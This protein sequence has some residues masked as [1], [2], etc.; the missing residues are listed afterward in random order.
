VRTLS[1]VAALVTAALACLEA[2]SLKY[3]DPGIPR[4][5]DGQPNLSAPA[6]RLNGKPDLS[7]VWQAERT[8]VS[9]FVRVLGP[10]LPA[11]QPDLNDI[12][13][14][15]LNV[16]W[17]LPPAEWPIRPE[18][19]A[20]TAERQKSGRDFPT[21]YCQP[22]SVPASM[23]ILDFKMIQAAREIVVLPGNGDPARQIYI[24]G[25][26]LPKDPEPSWMGSSVG[27]W[28][29]ET[30]VIDTTGFKDS[31]WLDGFG[32]P[33]SEGMHITE[34]Y[35]RRDFGHMDLEMSF[36]DPKYYTKPFGFKTTLTL[37]PDTDV[38]EYVCT[39][40]QRR[41]RPPAQ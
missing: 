31:A 15:V 11:I 21:A 1:I 5:K 3:H 9:E 22:G 39:E 33:R 12:T 36:D 17:D 32:H 14:H 25:R 29:G 24:D 10:G 20:L 38:L 6:P 35:R 23:L 28:Q 16:L 27:H 30:L 26:S 13:K 37:L 2:Q 40:N 7:G 18:A 4:S 41:Y 34:R 19:A 8:P